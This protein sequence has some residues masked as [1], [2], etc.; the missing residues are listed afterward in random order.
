MKNC[1]LKGLTLPLTQLN[2][3]GSTP[4][5]SEEVKGEYTKA[6]ELKTSKYF[7]IKAYKLLTKVGY[8]P[9]Q[10]SP[11]GRLPQQLANNNPRVGLRYTKQD[12][13]HIVINRATTNHMIEDSHSSTNQKK[14]TQVSVFDRL[15]PITNWR[16]GLS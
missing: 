13:L 1:A 5:L 9:Q 8:N 16:H 3:K 12:P 6:Q 4:Q 10:Q 7:A 11:L 15:G 14:S 2:Q